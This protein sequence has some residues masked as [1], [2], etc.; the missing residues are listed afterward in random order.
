M[1]ERDD[2]DV[3][4]FVQPFAALDEFRPEIAN[5][6]D[7]PAEA[8]HPEPQKHEQHFEERPPARRTGFKNFF[9]YGRSSCLGRRRRGK[10]REVGKPKDLL[11]LPDLRDG[12]LVA[13]L[14]ELLALDLFK[15]LSPISWSW[16]S[17]SASFQAGKT[18]VSSR[19][20]W[21]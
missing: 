18:I 5:M 7:R 4:R 15:D 9:A 19:A 8:R 16:R 14:A 13:V 17:E 12:I 6:R 11:D 2:I 3:S 20:A 1:T 10:L 21:F